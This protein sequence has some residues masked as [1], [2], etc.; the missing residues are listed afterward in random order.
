MKRTDDEAMLRAALAHD[1][2]TVA[3]LERMQAALVTRHA[4][5]RS[6]LQRVQQSELDRLSQELAGAQARRSRIVGE[7][8]DRALERMQPA[9]E[10]R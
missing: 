4:E 5:A 8:A 3:R 1:D 7:L 10:G 9:T 6:D 2:A